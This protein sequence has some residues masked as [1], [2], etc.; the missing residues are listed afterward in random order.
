VGVE[1]EYL[2]VD[3]VS[4]SPRP[5]AD[6]VQELARRDPRLDPHEVQHELLQAQVE[7]S[8]PICSSL[9]EVAGHLLRLRHAL[10]SAAE[11]AGCRLAACATST[12]DLEVAIPV[13]ATARYRALRTA[14]PRLVDE[15]LINGMHVHVA[16][17][18]RDTGVRVM[19][20]MRPWLP[21]LLALSA[22][23]PLWLGVDTGFA[24]WRH[25]VYSR[26]PVT[27]IPPLFRDARDYEERVARLV[28]GGLIGDPGQLYW[29]IRLSERYPTVEVRVCD[30]QLRVDEAVMLAGLIRALVMTLQEDATADEA[31]G[32]MTSEWLQAALWSAARHGIDDRVPDPWS[33]A[34]RK[35]GDVCSDALDYLSP[36]LEAT[37]DARHVVPL[38]HRLLREG[39]GAVRQQR[40]LGEGGWPALR[41]FLLLQTSGQ[42]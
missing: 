40:V 29:A 37:G 11:Q 38:V 12:G 32:R 13:T 20:R 42:G 23:S 27:G 31:G 9:P 30:I 10:G 28:A 39:N 36:A 19:N 7:V 21:L 41:D 33:G 4:G 17:P 3:P 25:L 34:L 1:E 5:I 15:Q 6:R 26:W 16:V 18:E 24:S 14:A 2:L 35:V 22:N 8:T